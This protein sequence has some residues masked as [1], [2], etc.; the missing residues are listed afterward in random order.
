[1]DIRL[2]CVVRSLRR[3]DHSSGGMLPTAVRRC[4]WSRNLKNEEAMARVGPQRHRK[5]KKNTTNYWLRATKHVARLGNVWSI[6]GMNLDENI[7]TASQD[8][9]ENVFCSARKVPLLHDASQ[10]CLWRLRRVCV[11]RKMWNFADSLQCK[12]RYKRTHIF[13]LTVP[14]FWYQRHLELWGN[15]PEMNIKQMPPNKRRVKAI[16]YS[17]LHVKCP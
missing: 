15:T 16:K 2:L 3:A 4:V 14:L 5:R 10:S 7:S 8:T 13:C 17:C 1:M 6:Q 11:G 12:R 9:G